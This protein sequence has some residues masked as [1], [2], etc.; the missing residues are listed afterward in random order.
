VVEAM[1]KGAPAEANA[2]ENL[3]NLRNPWNLQ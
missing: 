2:P 3:W 1:K